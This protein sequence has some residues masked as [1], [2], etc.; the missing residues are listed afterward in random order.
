VPVIS[1]GFHGRQSEGPS[2]RIPPGQYR[3]DDFPVLSA[4]PT[5]HTPL[6]QWTFTIEGGAKP[7]SWAWDEFRALPS[8]TVTVDIHCVTKWSKL[9]TVWEGVSMDTL[10]DR[11]EHDASYLVAFCDGGYTTNLPLADVTG[12]KAWVALSYGGEPLAPEHGGP[13][14]LLVPHLYFWKSA[15]WVRQVRFLEG[16]APGFWESLGYHNYGDPWREERYAGDE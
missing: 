7:M 3:T 14:R 1:R 10:L 6:E 5:P 2:D 9:D 13:A 15:K 12:G 16:D 8:E 4:G 11:V